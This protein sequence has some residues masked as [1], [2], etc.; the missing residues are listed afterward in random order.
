MSLL[1][2]CV[3]ANVVA[4]YAFS[5][6]VKPS[7]LAP[8]SSNTSAIGLNWPCASTAV[9]PTACNALVT[10]FIWVASSSLNPLAFI[11]SYLLIIVFKLLPIDEADSLVILEMVAI[12]DAAFSKLT[13]LF[14]AVLATFCKASPISSAPLAV[15]SPRYAKISTIFRTLSPV[16][17]A[18]AVIILL[19]SSRE[20]PDILAY[21][22]IAFIR[23]S[24][25]LSFKPCLNKSA[26]VDATS[27]VV[28]FISLAS[29]LYDKARLFTS[30]C[31]LFVTIRISLRELS[32]SDM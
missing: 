31:V 18:V 12:H 6:L 7:H 14:S 20:I 24:T 19:L 15:A 5:F 27:F 8:S 22:I 23:S 29:L 4:I 10:S 16:A 17:L 30:C 3:P 21:W 2:W 26:A 28:T 32:N 11:C 9:I 13:P 1:R 25:W